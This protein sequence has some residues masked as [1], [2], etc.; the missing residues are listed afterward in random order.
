[1]KKNLVY[2]VILSDFFQKPEMLNRDYLIGDRAVFYTTPTPRAD[3]AVFYTTPTPRAE[4]HINASSPFPDFYLEISG[5][6]LN[7]FKI[8]IGDQFDV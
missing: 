3:R 2:P 7:G 1:L 4:F 5:R 6:T 8:S